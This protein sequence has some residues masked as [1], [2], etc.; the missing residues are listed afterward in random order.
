M[1]G[2]S[3][4]VTC[5]GM[6]ADLAASLTPQ[7]E[8]AGKA[9]DLV[10]DVSGIQICGDDLPGQDSAWYRL[11]P[12]AALDD[13][14]VLVLFCHGTCFGR[15]EWRNDSINPPPAVWE[16]SPPPA[17]EPG[18]AGTVFSAER[19]SI[20]LY[21]HLL[22]AR[23]LVRRAVVGR[24]LPVGLIEAFS[25]AWAVYVDGRLARWG[26]PG[27]PLAERR[28]RFAEVFSPA[29]IL[30]PDHWQV[31]QSLWDGALPNQKDILDVVKRLPGL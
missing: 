11:Q 23:D 1:T 3:L 31:F 6:A 19:S 9:L 25:E 16:L 4:Q 22:T 12:G 29:G 7:A 27:Y 10:H 2:L 15:G 8:A 24:D 14:P 17:G 30:L 26:L 18:D 13:L 20:F 21:H 28:G 5:M